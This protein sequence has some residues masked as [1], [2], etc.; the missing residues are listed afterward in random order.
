MASIAAWCARRAV[1][2]SSLLT[3]GSQNFPS[4]YLHIFFGSVGPLLWGGVPWKKDS[5]MGQRAV[6]RVG[7]VEVEEIPGS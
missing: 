4:I 7:Y 1:A 6:V 2:K 5:L 3:K